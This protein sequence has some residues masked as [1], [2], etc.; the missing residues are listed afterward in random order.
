[1]VEKRTL[2]EGESLQDNGYLSYDITE[3][4]RNKIIET[5][6]D[7]SDGYNI[8]AG[9]ITHKFPK[10]NE[11]EK[12]PPETRMPYSSEAII[13]AVAQDEKA[14][15]LLVSIDGVTQREDGGMYHITLGLKER[16]QPYYSNQLNFRSYTK[17]NY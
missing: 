5:F 13:Y 17:S 8:V 16:V 2:K 11:G 15:A 10:L 4:S 9:H 3:E 6:S 14:M 12:I 1:M 7:K